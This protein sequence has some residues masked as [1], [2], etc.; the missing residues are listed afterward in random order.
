MTERA[1]HCFSHGAVFVSG[2]V[3]II[4]VNMPIC[5]G[6][7]GK[8]LLTLDPTER[9][10]KKEPGPHGAFPE[11]GPMRGQEGDIAPSASRTEDGHLEK[12]ALG[13]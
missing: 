11:H 4:N 3:S 9:I 7:T 8:A 6:L 2:C 10:L 13:N 1:S 12:A 5:L